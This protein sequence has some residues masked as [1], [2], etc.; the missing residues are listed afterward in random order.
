[1]CSAFV[2]TK[3]KGLPKSQVSELLAGFFQF[4][5][6]AL[7]IDRTKPHAHLK[8]WHKYVRH[9]MLCSGHRILGVTKALANWDDLSA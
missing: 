3:E 9:F 4:L 8:S 1:M 2:E 5:S 6:F 7:G